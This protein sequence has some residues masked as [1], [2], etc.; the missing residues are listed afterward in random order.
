MRGIVDSEAT[1]ASSGGDSA[2][3]TAYQLQLPGSP[4][5]GPTMRLVT[6]PP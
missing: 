1:L 6:Q 3:G 5:T 2:A 4:F